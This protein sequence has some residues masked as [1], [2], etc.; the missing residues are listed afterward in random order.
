[1]TIRAHEL[2][3]LLLSG[4][5][6]V[7]TTWDGSVSQDIAIEQVIAVPGHRETVVV[8]GMEMPA[9]LLED[10]EVLFGDGP[11][12]AHAVA[13]HQDQQKKAQGE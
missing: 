2:A 13:R 1:M 10:A 12:I 8:L 4:P 7:V 6:H 9:D 11:G 5:N 3:R